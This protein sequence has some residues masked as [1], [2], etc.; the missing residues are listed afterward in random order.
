MAIKFYP[1]PTVEDVA[2]PLMAEHHPHIKTHSVR[3]D[4]LFFDKEKKRNGM[5]VWGYATKISSLAAF[6]AGEEENQDDGSTEPF[7]VIAIWDVIWRTLNPDQR[8]ALVDHELAHCGAEYDDKGKTKLSLRGHDLEEFHAIYARYGAWRKSIQDFLDAGKLN[9]AT[10]GQTSFDDIPDEE[11]AT[12]SE[13]GL[14]VVNGDSG[15]VDSNDWEYRREDLVALP[16]VQ[17]LLPTGTEQ[18]M[19]TTG[20]KGV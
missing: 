15:S 12:T 9:D 11:T 1:A 8:K 20:S 14:T 10:V 17:A 18:A 13:T 2:R 19:V 4:F 3:L 5:T 6:L 16:S 7:F